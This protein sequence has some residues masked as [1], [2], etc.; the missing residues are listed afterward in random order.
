MRIAREL[1]DELIA[2]ARE[3][4]PDECCG[5]I[6]SRGDA[7]IV[8]HRTENADHSPLRYTIEPRDQL[9]VINAID[10]AGLELGAIY[11][12]HTRSDPVPSQTDINMAEHWPD[13]VYVIVGVKD[14]EVADVRAWRIADGG[15]S[16]VELTV[17]G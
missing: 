17:E 13:P 3:D 9:R 16:E 11:H 2:H 1:L 14:P 10:E 6:G 5:M 4:A 7:A 8:V 12:S 15:Y